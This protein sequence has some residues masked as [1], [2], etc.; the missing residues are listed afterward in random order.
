MTT[1]TEAVFNPNTYQQQL[2]AL[3]AR[4]QK[5]LKKYERLVREIERLRRQLKQPQRVI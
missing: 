5:D 3:T 4:Y 2:E 1:C